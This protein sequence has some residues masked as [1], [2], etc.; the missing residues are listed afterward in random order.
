MF[1]DISVLRSRVMNFPNINIAFWVSAFPTFPIVS[2]FAFRHRMRL[3]IVALAT[4]TSRMPF[5]NSGSNL[6]HSNPFTITT[7]CT[8]PFNRHYPL[9][10]NGGIL[11]RLGRHIEHLPKR[12]RKFIFLQRFSIRSSVVCHSNTSITRQSLPRNTS[13]TCPSCGHVDKKN[14]P[15]QSVFHCVSCDF[16]GVADHIAAVNISRLGSCHAAARLAA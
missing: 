15:S 8:L 14:R 13:R 11:D 9:S 1:L 2:P 3:C 4:H 7:L 6:R 16:A 10:P 5:F 12:F